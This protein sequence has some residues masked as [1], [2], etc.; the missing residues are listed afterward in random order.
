M[1]TEKLIERSNRGRLETTIIMFR[2]QFSLFF[3][4]RKKFFWVSNIYLCICICIP[5]QDSS[6]L[7]TYCFKK[8]KQR[9]HRILLN[10]IL[11][12][13]R[14]LPK[15][16]KFPL[17]YYTKEKVS[18]IIHSPFLE[19]RVMRGKSNFFFFILVKT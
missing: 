15:I 5:I 16:V 17:P 2:V 18:I 12:G 4:A 9:K 11:F 6:S 10:I 13:K 14:R 8:K 3:L 7:S 1:A 19:K